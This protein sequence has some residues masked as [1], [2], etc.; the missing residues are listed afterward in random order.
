MKD[1]FNSSSNPIIKKAL[2]KYKNMKESGMAVYFDVDELTMLADHYADRNEIEQADEIIEYGLTLYPNETELLCLKCHSFIC[3][4]QLSEAESTLNLITDKQDY[5]AMLLQG[6]LHLAYENE[7]AANDIFCDLYQAEEEDPY[8]ALDIAELYI[9]YQVKEKALFWIKKAGPNDYKDLERTAVYAKYYLLIGNYKKAAECFSK[10]LDEEPYNLEA[11]QSLIRCYIFSDEPEKIQNALEFA[12]AIDDTNPINLELQ[13][14]FYIIQDNF[15]RAIECLKAA[16]VHATDKTS[17]YF[18]LMSIYNSKRDYDKVLDYSNKI[19]GKNQLNDIDLSKVYQNRANAYLHKED[20]QSCAE[21][22]RMGLELCSDNEELYILVGRFFLHRDDTKRA[23]EA[24]ERAKQHSKYLPY[25]LEAIARHCISEYYIDKA[26]EVLKGIDSVASDDFIAYFYLAFCYYKKEDIDNA[27]KSLIKFNVCAPES[28]EEFDLSLPPTEIENFR[29][30]L[31][32]LTDA[33][34]HSG[35]AGM[36]QKN[37]AIISYL[38]NS[39][40]QQKL[41]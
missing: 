40:T 2:E 12:M 26:I 28:I 35:A 18:T 38:K 30:Y 13:G 31:V 4:N 17:I 22:L 23:E 5:E 32:E 41:Q 21:N 14:N 24:F 1:N 7:D 33:L 6:E 16:E 27:I 19:L 20:Y 37:Y 8:T 3:K 25:T 11:W 29:Q 9:S 36:V 15:E 34:E 39:N 10:E